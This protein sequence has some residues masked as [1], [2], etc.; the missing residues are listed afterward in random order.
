ML[1]STARTALPCGA[2][3]LM[4]AALSRAA[5]TSKEGATKQIKRT[6]TMLSVHLPARWALHHCTFK[7]PIPTVRLIVRAGYFLRLFIRDR[8]VQIVIQ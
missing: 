1:P 2:E 7:K 4:M 6:I 8:C 3:L 5:F